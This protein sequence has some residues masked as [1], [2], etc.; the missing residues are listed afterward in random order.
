MFMQ[1]FCGV[2]VI[3]YYSTTIFEQ[4]NFSDISAFVASFGFGLSECRCCFFNV[5]SSHN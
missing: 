4:A 5:F 1:Q 2:N 3:A